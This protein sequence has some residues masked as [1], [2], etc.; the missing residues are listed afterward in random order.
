MTEQTERRV[1][2]QREHQLIQQVS[3]RIELTEDELS[4]IAGGDGLSGDII[5]NPK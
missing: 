1:A 2:A 5:I 3:E 4:L